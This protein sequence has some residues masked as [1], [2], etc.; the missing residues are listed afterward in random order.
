MIRPRSGKA[1]SKEAISQSSRD[2]PVIPGKEPPQAEA[3]GYGV[4]KEPPQAEACGYGVESCRSRRLQP[5]AEGTVSCCSPLYL[6]GFVVKTASRCAFSP[7]EVV[8]SI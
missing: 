3:C 1:L 6:E 4:E 2:M 7:D 5:A 8:K